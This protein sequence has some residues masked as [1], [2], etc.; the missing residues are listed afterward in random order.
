M[1]SKKIK[2]CLV[3]H[4][5][6]I[7]NKKYKDY[8]RIGGAEVQLF[9]LSK[10]F[11]KNDNFEANLII[12]NYKR[13]ASIE[14]F[15]KIKIFGLRS[16]SKKLINH[17][18]SMIKLFFTLKQINPDFVIKRA[19]SMVTGV[20]A[21]YCRIFKKNFIYS[22]ANET[23]V[24]GESEK[25]IFGKIYKFGLDNATYLVAQNF[26][27][28]IE[29]EKFK[30]RK[31]YNIKVI[32]SGYEIKKE[33]PITQKEIILWV[34]RAIEWKRPEMFFMLAK[35]FPNEKFI[36]IC[37]EV[38]YKKDYYKTIVRKASNLKNL[39]FIKFVPFHEIDDYFKQAKILINTSIYEGFPNTFIQAFR[40]GTPVIS[41]NVNPDNIFSKNKIGYFC[42]D[43]FEKMKANL[44]LLLE[45]RDL[46]KTYSK[47]AYHFC[48]ENHDIKKIGHQWIQLIDTLSKL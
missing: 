19:A 16:L 17:F 22:I 28:I 23:D 38:N 3:S 34:A 30:K 18:I 31:F 33:E 29:L 43:D 9:L 36:M 6:P 37:N 47:N 4:G 39:T 48:R 25:N 8:Y 2:V 11:A 44:S 40:N 46:Y 20:C 14:F 45:K 35:Q 5:Y 32:K 24:N 12:G 15:E 21:L 41:L 27:Q 13:K 26:N 7:Y 10:E 1:L 42:N